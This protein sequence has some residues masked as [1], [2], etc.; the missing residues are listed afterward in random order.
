MQQKVSAFSTSSFS[1]NT[2]LVTFITGNLNIQSMK[3]N[4][5]LLTPYLL[6]PAEDIELNIRNF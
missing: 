2:G 4:H 3:V 5:V 1:S 6:A